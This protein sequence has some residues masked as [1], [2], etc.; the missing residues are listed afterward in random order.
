MSQIIPY[1]RED[2]VAY[3]RKWALGRNPAYYDFD[4]LGGDCTN[5]ISQ[6]LFSGSNIMNYTPTYGWY[7]I[8][9][10]RRTPS[11]TGVRYLYN[12][13]IQNKTKAV[14]GEETSLASVQLGDIIQLAKQDIGFYH[15]LIITR[16][17]GEI[18][19]LDN[20]YICTH[21][22]DSLDRPLNT[23]LYDTL[24]CIHILGVYQ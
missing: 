1:R 17:D 12:F 11:W 8:N 15:S 16:I 23:Y 3:A 22:F 7:Y 14:F 10:N 24:R 2:A 18:P 5:F 6:C 20:I 21:T 9:A 4:N 19:T 13:L